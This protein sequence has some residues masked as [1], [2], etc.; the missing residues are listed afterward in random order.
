MFAR[1]FSYGLGAAMVVA[2]ASIGYMASDRD[3]PIEVKERIIVTPKVRPGGELVQKIK[4][5]EKK[6]CWL[7]SDRFVFDSTGERFPLEPVEFQAGIGLV[8]SDE[9]QTYTIS[10]KLPYDIAFGPA[11]YISST[12]HKCDLLDWVWP[13]YAPVTEIKFEVAPL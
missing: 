13:I 1:Y 6:R 3:P 10:I 12:V 5:V 2:G 4:V 8:K 7:H 11:R 9:E